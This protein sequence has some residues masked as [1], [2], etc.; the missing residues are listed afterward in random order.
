MYVYTGFNLGIHSEL[1]LPELTTSNTQADITI[2]LGNLNDLQG[3]HSNSNDYFLGSIEGVGMVLVKEGREIILDP[4]PE[5][6]ES[7]LRPFILGA[8]I[9]ILLRQRGLLVLHA[10]SVAINGEAIAFIGESGW[11]KSTLAEAFHSQGYSILTDDVMA[12]S[13]DGYQ[14]LV[15]PSF[16]QVRL[17]SDTAAAV[18]HAPGSLPSLS[19]ETP[20]LSHILSDGFVQTPLPLKRIY[21]LDFAA[22]FKIIPVDM[23]TSFVELMRHSREVQALKTPEHMNAYLHLCTSLLKQVPVYRLQ[24]KRSLSALSNL[25]DLITSDISPVQ[26]YA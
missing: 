24:R 1:P 20:K 3:E 16:P 15:I 2:R 10:S 26:C 6:D 18:G 14:P 12:V 7:I 19:I 25:V 11:G 8:V 4:N 21:V 9:S 17:W 13:V 5:I 23:Q 22:E